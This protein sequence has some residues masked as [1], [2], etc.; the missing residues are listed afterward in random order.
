MGRLFR[1]RD[2]GKSI[3]SGESL[4]EIE[5]GVIFV[6]PPPILVV[7]LHIGIDHVKLR[8]VDIG[9]VLDGR[10]CE[11]QQVIVRREILCNV[12]IDELALPVLNGLE[13]CG[14]C[15]LVVGLLYQRSEDPKTDGEGLIR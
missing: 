3:D 5:P 12:A 13:E 1:S 6:F 8:V 4:E 11:M 10:L 2:L 14:V 15:H 7:E 9:A